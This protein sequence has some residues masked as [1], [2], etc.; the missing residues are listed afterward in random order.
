MKNISEEIMSGSLQQQILPLLHSEQ[1][2]SGGPTP[3]Q[4]P[5]E[6]PAGPC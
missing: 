2:K 5:E 4:V 1:N 3:L 6:I